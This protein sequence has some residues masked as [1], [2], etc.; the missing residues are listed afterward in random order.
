MVTLSPFW[1]TDIVSQFPESPQLVPSPFP[2]HV[3]SAEA[4]AATGAS[5]LPTIAPAV[6]AT[7]SPDRSQQPHH[8]VMIPPMARGRIPPYLREVSPMAEYS[9]PRLAPWGNPAP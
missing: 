8:L 9:N 5:M 3:G 1:G 7:A 4:L 2:V 6:A